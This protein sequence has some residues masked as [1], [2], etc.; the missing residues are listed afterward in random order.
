MWANLVIAL[1]HFGKQNNR[2]F[3]EQL[4]GEHKVRPYK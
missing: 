4:Q 1:P 2:R 3:S